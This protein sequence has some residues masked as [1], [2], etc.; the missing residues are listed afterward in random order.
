MTKKLFVLV[1]DG[2]DGSY[3]PVYTFNEKWIQ[4]QEERY[5]NDELDYESVGC[6]VDGFHYDILYVPDECTPETMGFIDYG[7]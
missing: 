3:N 6:D 1:S 5:E 4:E 7:N 2:G